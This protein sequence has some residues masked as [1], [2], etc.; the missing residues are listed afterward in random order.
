MPE[1]AAGCLKVFFQTPVQDISVLCLSGLYTL[2]AERVYQIVQCLYNGS[3]CMPE[4]SAD[5][6]VIR[7]L[8]NIMLSMTSSAAEFPLLHLQ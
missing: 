6:H 2:E 7:W 1:S 3:F 8:G 4:D 5:V